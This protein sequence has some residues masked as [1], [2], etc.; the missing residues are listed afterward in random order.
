[1]HLDEPKI[2]GIVNL[3]DDSFYDGGRYPSESAVLRRV[4]QMLIEGADIFD[5]GAQSTRPGA[6]MVGVEIESSK[7]RQAVQAVKK[8][9][10][11][12]ILSVDTFRSEV[13]KVGLD[14]GAS[15]INDVSG[16][17][18]DE[19]MFE[20]VASYSVPYVIMH[21]RGNTKT[22]MDMTQ[23][24]DFPGDILFELN[25]QVE[26]AKNAGIKDIIIDPGFGF[27][28]NLDQNFE[29]L[30][31]L[32]YFE[33]M[34]LPILVGLSRKS[35]IYKF[36]G[37]NASEALNGTSVLNTFALWFGAHILRVHDVKE[38]KQTIR[39]VQKLRS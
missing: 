33:A 22:M 25:Q 19:C 9:F 6:D 13:A 30:R 23:Y 38:A 5:F 34:D 7:I 29:L 17:L 21:Y 28:K 14:E 8:E 26:K 11:D 35:M 36:L 3:T 37:I 1:M 18:L 10:P 4:E 16:G 24:A 2:M 32:N 39:L 20:I 27:A 12:A 15:I 31:K